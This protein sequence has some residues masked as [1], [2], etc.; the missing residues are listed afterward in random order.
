MTA[1][2]AD[3]RTVRTIFWRRFFEWLLELLALGLLPWFAHLIVSGGTDSAWIRPELYL[4]VMVISVTSVF[5]VLKD[6]ATINV[7]KPLAAVTGIVGAVLAP[8]AY[9]RLSLPAGKGA[10]EPP[11]NQF[12]QASV[13]WMIVVSLVVYGIYRVPIIAG[14]AKGEAEATAA[15]T[16]GQ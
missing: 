15:G 3:R 12:L 1:P 13:L 10:A 7:T 5:D 16:G 14:Q 6:R 9:A 11:G 8:A 4:F 2:A